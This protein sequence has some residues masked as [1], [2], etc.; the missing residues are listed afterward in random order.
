MF[1]NTFV[2]LNV[3]QKICV[4]FLFLKNSLPQSV[5]THGVQPASQSERGRTGAVWTSLLQSKNTLMERIPGTFI[6]IA[7]I[8]LLMGYP[9]GI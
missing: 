1:N 7:T 5:D 3:L 9:D 2:I 6:A 8:L 4:W